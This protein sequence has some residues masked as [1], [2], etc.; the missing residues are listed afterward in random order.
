MPQR[1]WRKTRL[2][3]AIA[4]GGLRARAEGALAAGPLCDHCLGRLFAEVDTGLANAERGRTVREALGGAAPGVPCGVCG[5]LFERV[6]IWANQAREALVGWEFAALA[7]A[8]HADGRIDGREQQLWQKVGA[9]TAEPYKQEFNR[10]LGIRLCETIGCETDLRRPDVIVVADHAAGRVTVAV[11]PL[12]V[13]GRYRKL[14]RGLPQCRWHAW[15]TSIQQL[16][17]DPIRREARAEDHLFHG[18]GRE[19]TD[20]RC[21]G[22]RP[23]VLEVLRPHRR[24][25]DWHAL[26]QEINGTGQ[27]VVLGLGPCLRDEVARLKG[28]R[29]DKTYRAVVTPAADLDAA[30]CGRL[31]RL[32]GSIAQRTP[33]RV[34]NRRPDLVRRRR[35]LALEWNLLAPRRLELTVRAQAGTYV[36]E[37]VSG[38]GG[39]TSPSVAEILGAAAV[40]AELDV[41]A[42]HLDDDT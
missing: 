15:P 19:D 24:R 4:E 14:V 17:G 33:T 27:V 11:E 6:G 16:I 38:D 23:F 35:I 18:C 42:I 34:L 40:C 12:F 29:P 21:L 7:V 20:V 9:D 37:L 8:S 10:L 22:E 31:A 5:G 25:L 30:R 26:T 1:A 13:R 41:L 36:K 32:V 28:L 3:E 2:S 39:R